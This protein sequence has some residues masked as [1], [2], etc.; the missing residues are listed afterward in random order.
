MK[1]VG[2]GPKRAWE[3]LP[4]GL[5]DHI[6]ESLHM[7][8][9]SSYGTVGWDDFFLNNLI[10]LLV[11]LV[12]GMFVFLFTIIFMEIAKPEDVKAYEDQIYN[13]KVCEGRVDDAP[14]HSRNWFLENCNAQI[15][16]KDLPPKPEEVK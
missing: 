8:R 3:S 15:Q 16:A 11:T 14:D 10:N 2:S 9:L 13:N 5:R 1:V 4:R 7:K 12:I 6:A